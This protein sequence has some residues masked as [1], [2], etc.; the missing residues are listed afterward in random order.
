MYKM[1][2]GCIHFILIMHTFFQKVTVPADS[3]WSSTLADYIRN[4]DKPLVEECDKVLHAYEDELLPCES[5]AEMI[6]VLGKF[7]QSEGGM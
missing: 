2:L 7:V 6:D 3:S 1:E 4:N 5:V